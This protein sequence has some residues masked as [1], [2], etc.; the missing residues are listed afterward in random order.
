VTPRPFFFEKKGI[1][2][3][4]KYPAADPDTFFGRAAAAGGA[5]ILLAYGRADL[6]VLQLPHRLELRILASGGRDLLA[7]RELP[8]RQLRLGLRGVEESEEEGEQRTQHYRG[9]NK[10]NYGLERQRYA[11]SPMHATTFLRPLKK[12]SPALRKLEGAA[13]GAVPALPRK[14]GGVGIQALACLDERA[15]L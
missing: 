14:A 3:A 5:A 11:F 12:N 6:F 1:G 15:S 4:A 8:L 9:K 2:S 10:Q 7:E 13:A